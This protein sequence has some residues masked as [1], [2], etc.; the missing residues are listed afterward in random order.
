MTACSPFSRLVV[1]ERTGS[2]NTDLR[3]ALTGPDGALDPA[4]SAAWPHLSA[5]RAVAQT[6][7]RGRADH[8]WTTPPTGA[9]TASIV[10]RPLVPAA[11]LA[12]LPLLAGLAVARALAPRLEST[13]WSVATKWP[14]DVVAVPTPAALAP[15]EVPGWGTSRKVAGI[16]TELIGAP[17]GSEASDSAAPARRGEA[18][19]VVVGIGINLAQP[20][21][22]LPVPWAASLASLG[23]PAPAAAAVLEDCGR[24]LAELLADW[25][26]SNG[27]PDAG[28]G[29]LGTQLRGACATLGQSVR[30]TGPAETITGTAVDLAPGLVLQVGDGTGARRVVVTAG[31]VT[32]VRAA[33]VSDGEAGR[34]GGA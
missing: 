6:A 14:N 25:E 12:W 15:A 24:H 32:G 22:Q 23:A 29:A 3:L 9:L 1:V 31:E 18:P 21:A 8:T 34:A 27:D 2:T 4:A 7:G 28:A 20:A 16:L 11:S 10:V 30:V 26:A 5:L 17:G 33:D 13:G 19:A